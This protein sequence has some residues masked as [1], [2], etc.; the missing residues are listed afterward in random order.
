[1]NWFSRKI[2]Q[3]QNML[4]VNRGATLSQTAS[5]PISEADDGVELSSMK[6]PE[7]KALAKELGIKGYYKMNK[8]DL[9]AALCDNA[10]K[11]L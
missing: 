11:M 9:I 8:A 7:L 3:I 5:D 6:V 10:N 4:T 2:S 1:M